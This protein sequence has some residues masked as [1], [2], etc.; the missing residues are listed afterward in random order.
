M[1][2]SV[3]LTYRIVCS[4]VNEKQAERSIEQD[5][6]NSIISEMKILYPSIED[7]V[8]SRGKTIKTDSI[9]VGNRATVVVV[10]VREKLSDKDANKIRLWLNQRTGLDNLIVTYILEKD[11][12][13]TDTIKANDKGIQ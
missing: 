4:T 3:F 1:I 9:S 2:P 7:I 8:V 6:I 10:A 12:C 13:L 5:D 11:F